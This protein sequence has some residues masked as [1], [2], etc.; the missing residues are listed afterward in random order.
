MRTTVPALM[1]LV[2]LAGCAI[3]PV[4]QPG[5]GVS[6]VDRKYGAPTHILAQPDGGELWQYATQPFGVTFINV[7]LAADGTVRAVWDGLSDAHRARI[8]AGMR[9]AEVVALLGSRRSIETYA[10]SGESV[11]DWNIS[12]LGRP[13][14]A[15]RFNVHFREG[16]VVRTSMSYVYPRDGAFFGETGAGIGRGIGFGLSIEP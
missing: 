16:R 1:L 3:A 12:N 6:A 10:L 13:G 2:A 4:P 14:I 9:E 11:W 15:T 8:V 5:D 7:H